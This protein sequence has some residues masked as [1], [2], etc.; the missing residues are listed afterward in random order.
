MLCVAGL[1]GKCGVRI[2][3]SSGLLPTYTQKTFQTADGSKFGF[4]LCLQCAE[5]FSEADWPGMLK[6]INE[7][8]ALNGG[9]RITAN[10]DSEV[11]TKHYQ[12]FIYSAQGG[13]CIGCHEVIDD[14]WI[15][16]AGMMLHEKCDIPEQM[17]ATKSKEVFAEK[18]VK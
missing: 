7:W 13:R 4:A 10:I 2:G 3:S 8:S 9:P 16:T 18:S 6:A 1:C 12:D 17:V 11:E 15:I 14:K 5:G